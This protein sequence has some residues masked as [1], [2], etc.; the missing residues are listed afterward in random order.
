MFV[1]ILGTGNKFVTIVDFCERPEEKTPMAV[2]LTGAKKTKT[3]YGSVLS[4]ANTL[5]A[6]ISSEPE[7]SWANHKVMRGPFDEALV[8]VEKFVRESEF[9]R[10]FGTIVVAYLLR[11]TNK[12]FYM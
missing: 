7:W 2:A 10:R 3:V 9:A 12:P 4:T 5:Q 11:I 1:M 6:S 8:A